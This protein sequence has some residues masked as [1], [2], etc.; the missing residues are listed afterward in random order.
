M[1]ELHSII[2]CVLH[3]ILDIPI[4]MGECL[5]GATCFALQLD[6]S[7]SMNWNSSVNDKRHW[8]N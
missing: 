7:S 8:S 6:I 5:D 4:K 2:R 1:Y 3:P